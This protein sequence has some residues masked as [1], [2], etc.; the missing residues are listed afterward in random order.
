MMKKIIFLCVIA[1][2]TGC[3]T[4][5][6]R[7]D[8]SQFGRDAQQAPSRL[9]PIALPEDTSPA[10]DLG[11]FERRASS[12]PG[13]YG[14]DE[15]TREDLSAGGRL[16]GY[17]DDAFGYDEHSAALPRAVATPSL[18]PVK[19]AILLPLSG[20]SADLGQAMLQAAQLALFDINYRSFELIPRDTNGTPEGARAAAEAAI[21]S[22]AEL[23][24]GPLFA[25]SVRA[26]KPVASRHNINVIAFSTDWTLAGQGTYIMGFLPFAQVQRVAS[27]SAAQGYE[28]IAILTPNNDY[29]NAVVAAYNSIAYRVGLRR[30]NVV[31]F[32]PDSSDLS[33]VVR[34][35]SQYDRRVNALHDRK[36]ALE[37]QVEQNPGDDAARRELRD[38]GRRDTWGDPPFDAV[39][40]P[41]GGEQARSVASLL[42]YYDLGPKV[43][44]RLGTGLWDD[45]GLAT[46]PALEGAWFAAPAPDQRRD[47]ERRYIDL[48]GLRPPRLSTL[49]YDATALAAVLARNGFRTQDAPDFSHRALTNPNGYAGIDGIFRFR[50]DGL[51]ERGLAVL[52]YRDARISVVEPAPTTFQQLGY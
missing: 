10:N 2:V 33:D 12:R 30:A 52:E 38:L 29:G 24:L 9:I 1:L 43:M 48:Y 50:P 13:L 27:Y 5:A 47:F 16:T 32:S 28:N 14:A 18:P 11:G 3:A 4:S 34:Q 41:V 17:D 7:W 31:R 25:H 44:K 19:V 15:I 26:V 6:P 51:V 20:D 40:M 42:S 45:P 37:R 46:E 23:I 35:F 49:A 39:L 21:E 22:G 36:A 8:S